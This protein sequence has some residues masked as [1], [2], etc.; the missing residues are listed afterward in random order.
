MNYDLGT[1]KGVVVGIT[2]G[3]GLYDG[4]QSFSIAKGYSAPSWTAA[5]QPMYDL[6]MAVFQLDCI[7]YW[8]G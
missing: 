2:V 8:A 5:P 4:R 6:Q 3:S 1:S 7:K